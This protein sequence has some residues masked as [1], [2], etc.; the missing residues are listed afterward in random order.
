[1]KGAENPD[2]VQT[3]RVPVTGGKIWYRAIGRN[4]SKL[5]L[6]VVHGGPGATHD[7]L[8]PL[9]ALADER[10]VIFYDQL[11]CGNSEKTDNPELWT[12]E[13]YRDELHR[14]RL[15][16]GLRKFCILGQSWGAV[17]AVEYALSEQGRDTA[18]LVLSGPMLSAARW[19][20]DQKAHIAKLS[21]A[22]RDTIV[23]IE[24]SGEF[25]SPAYQ[26][27]V[28]EYYRQHV[29][30]LERWPDCLNKTF[31][32]VNMR[33]YQAMWGPSEFTIT[34]TL[35][36]YD[37]VARLDGITAPVL[38][39]CGQ[40]DE[41]AP[42]TVRLFQSRIPNAE[43]HVFDGASH[44]HH[45]EKPEEYLSVVRDFLGRTDR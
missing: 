32:K 16:L 21:P 19:A 3:G 29:C 1:M 24:A 37:C 31:A 23:K 10:P 18:G 33:L 15:A 14:L 17:P 2:F 41:A 35:R 44:E 38:L 27:A 5:P 20:A 26:A 6:L 11:D 12:V 40:H 39:T 9:A 28:M 25:D 43:V 42:E 7:Y 36:N 45:L 13:R 30:R 8:E 34:G 4:R 22:L